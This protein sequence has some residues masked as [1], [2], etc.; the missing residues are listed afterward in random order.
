MQSLVRFSAAY[1]VQELSGSLVFAR[2][3]T[4][5]DK[6]IA[7]GGALVEKDFGI[8]GPIL[9]SATSWKLIFVALVEGMLLGKYAKIYRDRINSIAVLWYGF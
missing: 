4:A 3:L 5:V 6:A 7:C 1:L 2:P 8:G 9:V